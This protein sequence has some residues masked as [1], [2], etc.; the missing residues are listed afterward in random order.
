MT[1]LAWFAFG[2]GWVGVVGALAVY[3]PMLANVDFFRAVFQW[4]E[5][6]R[7]EDGNVRA[8]TVVG[9]VTVWGVVCS[10]TFWRRY[11]Q[12]PVGPLV[13]VTP[14]RIRV[15]QAALA[16]AAANAGAWLALALIQPD[17]PRLAAKLNGL[18]LLS[19]VYFVAHWGFTPENLFPVRF[20]QFASNPMRYVFLY[21]FRPTAF[22]NHYE[23]SLKRG[24]WRL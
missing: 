12:W 18:L 1:G 11:G 22:H 17:W 16:V 5:G 20:L 4:V 21:L 15:A 24:Y 19:G 10:Y 7:S 3:A 6:G 23:R 13:V 14:R 9:V 2:Y 8:M